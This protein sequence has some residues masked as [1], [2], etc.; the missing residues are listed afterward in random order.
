MGSLVRGLRSVSS[1]LSLILGP[2]RQSVILRSLSATSG[3]PKLVTK[4]SSLPV[5]S[6]LK[7]K[8]RQVKK[9]PA[10][11]SSGQEEWNVVGYSAAET[12]DLFGLQDALRE[13]QLYTR[14]ELPDELD[15]S[16]IY[17]S[18]ECEFEEKRR[19]ILLFK[20][21]CVVFWNVP[22]LERGQVLAYLKPF[23]ENSYEESTVFEESE[24]LTYRMS[25]TKKNH[26][27]KGVINI[28]DDDDV[29]A[30]YT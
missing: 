7:F 12:F 2:P 1:S 20:E 19:D 8:V 25:S 13:Q 17:V 26:F 28:Q 15:P 30:K 4:E 23:S 24:M 9:K 27:H 14:V 11:S 3:S 16:C 21:G 18:N 10:K 29:L 22:E 5:S 6:A